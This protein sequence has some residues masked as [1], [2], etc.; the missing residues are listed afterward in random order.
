MLLSNA[1][2]EQE[3]GVWRIQ[4]QSMLGAATVCG[5]HGAK[6]ELLSKSLH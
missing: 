1:P 6:E 3:L 2:V 5:M 4:G